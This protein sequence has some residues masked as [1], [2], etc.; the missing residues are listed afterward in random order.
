L[1]KRDS[2]QVRNRVLPIQSAVITQ[3]QIFGYVR[4]A[5]QAKSWDIVNLNTED[6]S[7]RS[8]EA[9]NKDDRSLETTRGF[10]VA[11]SFVAGLG[12]FDHVDNAV[13]GIQRM[14]Q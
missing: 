3:N 5:N 2:D 1:V 14:S 9:F 11:G 13:L 7:R 6:I 4:D 8:W 10:I 12:L